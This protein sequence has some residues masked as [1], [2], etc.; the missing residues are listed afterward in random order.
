MSEKERI[1]SGTFIFTTDDFLLDLDNSQGLIDLSGDGLQA[2]LSQEN[3]EEAPLKGKR[4]SVLGHVGDRSLTGDP[5]SSLRVKSL[6][7]AKLVLQSDI[8]VRA[9]YIFQSGQGGSILDNWLCAERE[10]LGAS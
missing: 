8:A 3:F 5:N 9:Y 10:L 1:F 2:V 6:I 7:V 4:V